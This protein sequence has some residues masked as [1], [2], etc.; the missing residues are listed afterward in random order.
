PPADSIPRPPKARL[1]TLRAAGERRR[2]TAGVDEPS[3]Q[4]LLLAPHELCVPHQPVP[5]VETGDPDVHRAPGRAVGFEGNRDR[6]SPAA[7]SGLVVEVARALYLSPE[8]AEV[9]H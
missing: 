3:D 5:G 1:A 6:R 2:L 8:R 4:T 9:A 7:Y